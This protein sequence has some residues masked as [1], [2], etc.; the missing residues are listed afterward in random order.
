M[1]RSSPTPNVL[2]KSAQCINSFCKAYGISDPWR[3]KNPTSRQYSFYF[4]PHLT[5]TRI[6][7][8]LLDNKLTPTVTDIEYSGIVISDHS[9]V[10]LKLCFPGNMAPQRMW[11]L[12]SRLLADDNFTKFI[13]S[14]IDFFLEI[15][16]NP[17]M[18]S[19]ILWESFYGK[20]ETY[21]RIIEGNK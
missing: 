3:V 7:Y 4:P 20:D 13:N 11:R 18:S 12:N 14:Q 6:D 1:D 5:Y 9:P 21:H 10:I 2:S 16:D 8:F 19:G 15:N 17:D